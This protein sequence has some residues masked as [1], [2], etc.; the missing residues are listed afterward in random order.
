MQSQKVAVNYFQSTEFLNTVQVVGTTSIPYIVLISKTGFSL[1]A[2]LTLVF[3]GLVG[4]VVKAKKDL[5]LSPNLYTP[6]GV[7]GTDPNQAIAYV[8]HNI[9]IE[10]ATDHVIPSAAREVINEV[11]DEILETTSI[12]DL[13]RPFAKKA[14]RDFL[15]GLF[16]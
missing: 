16:R 7:A 8:A 4:G 1:E 14:S 5:E 11:A 12:P 15:G 13:L 2:V 6:V 10:K 3:A 9:A